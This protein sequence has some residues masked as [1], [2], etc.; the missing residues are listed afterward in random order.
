MYG[1]LVIRGIICI[2]GIIAMFKMSR[3]RFLTVYK[4]TPGTDG[5]FAM[6]IPDHTSLT[7]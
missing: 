5:Q 2:Y 7:E 1:I 4:A 3:I 6:D